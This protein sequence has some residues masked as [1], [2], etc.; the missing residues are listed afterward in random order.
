VPG[1]EHERIAWRVEDP[2]QRD[3]ELDHAKVR[4]EVAA[5]LRDIGDE[6]VPHLRRQLGELLLRE[7]VEITGTPDRLEKGHADRLSL[8]P[9]ESTHRARA[10]VGPGRSSRSH[11]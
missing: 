5:R 8:L 2:V 4:T 10:D 3:G 11:V 7:S 9:I 1:V 6:E